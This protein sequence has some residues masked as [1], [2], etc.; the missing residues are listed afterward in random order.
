M[1]I[2]LYYVTQ[3]GSVHI[4]ATFIVQREYS[5]T[6][7]TPFKTIFK[8]LLCDWRIIRNSNLVLTEKQ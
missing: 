8:V 4:F 1:L 3:V 7:P 2:I 5:D 6:I